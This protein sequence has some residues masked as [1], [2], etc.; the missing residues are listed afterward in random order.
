ML[1]FRMENNNL[2]STLL[3]LIFLTHSRPNISFVV[4]WYFGA[5]QQI[6]FTTTKRILQYIKGTCYGIFYPHVITTTL[7]SY[8]NL[9]W[10]R[11]LNK[12]RSMLGMVIKLGRAPIH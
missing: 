3:D 7:I 5:P 9:D 4:S 11:N 12:R 2:V 6:H 10:D 8:T 1:W